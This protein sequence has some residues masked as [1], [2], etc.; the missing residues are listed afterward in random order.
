MI[1]LLGVDSNLTE[2]P[3]ALYKTLLEI[4]KLRL[5]KV[6]LWVMSLS[7]SGESK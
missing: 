4:V 5:S 6:L 7:I 2:S 3:Q 1:A